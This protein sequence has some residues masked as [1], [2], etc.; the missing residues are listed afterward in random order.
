MKSNVYF[1]I[2]VILQSVRA[3][4]EWKKHILRSINQ[5]MARKTILENLSDNEVFIE[6]DWAMKFIPLQYRESQSSW[7]G[8]RGLN[9]H[10]TVTTFK[11]QDD[12]ASHTIFH[13]FDAATQDAETSNAVLSHALKMLSEMKPHI[14]VAYI[15]SDNAGCF[16]GLSG[17]RYIYIEL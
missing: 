10:V 7:F 8:K 3:V 14:D 17:L 4:R 9:W 1:C 6:R 13:I 16:H 5:D 11:N 15:R 12:L 2:F